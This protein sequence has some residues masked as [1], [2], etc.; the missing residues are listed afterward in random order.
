ML[1]ARKSVYTIILCVQLCVKVSQLVVSFILTRKQIYPQQIDKR[2]NA[3]TQSS[4]NSGKGQHHE[5][6]LSKSH[7]KCPPKRIVFLQGLG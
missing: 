5:S 3:A 7:A 2:T 6:V 1:H 4:P